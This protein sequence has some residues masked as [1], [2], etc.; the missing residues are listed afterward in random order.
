MNNNNSLVSVIIPTYNAGQYLRPALQ[1]ILDQTYKN[2]EI[3]VVDDGSTDSCIDTISDLIEKNDSVKLISKENGGKS[4]ALNVALDQAKGEFFVIQDAD[5]LSYPQRIEQQ[6]KCLQEN[7]ELAAV[8]AGHDL[9]LNNKRF[10]PIFEERTVEYCGQQAKKLKMPAHDAVLMCR[11]SMVGDMRYDTELRIGQGLEYTLRVCLKYP[12]L[13]IPQ[14]LYTYRINYD[15]TIRKDPNKTVTQINLALEKICTQHGFDFEKHKIPLL[16]ESHVFKHRHF[17][18]H[19]IPHCMDSI[20]QLK[21][22]RNY[23]QAFRSA[24]VCLYL[25]PFDPY[26]YKPFVYCL[27]PLSIINKHRKKKNSK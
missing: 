1:S 3:I 17:D 23:R 25:R 10:A 6:V 22:A 16:P 2:L 18:T 8:F 26:Y 13:K 27:T 24:F 11:M 9:L 4:T 12:V 7:P 20:V 19:I 14:C 21:E 5:D 15:S